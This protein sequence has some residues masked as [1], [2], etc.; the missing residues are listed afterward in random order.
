MQW[1]II[2][3]NN[4]SSDATPQ[5]FEGLKQQWS[6]PIPL[7]YLF[8]PQ[9]GIAF[10]RQCGVEQAQGRLV[11][12]L[13]DDNWPTERWIA[14]AV[15]FHDQYPQAGAYG[16]R[17]EG[18]FE[19]PPPPEVQPLFRF[20]A[21]R[22]HGPQ[23][24]RFQPERLQLPAGAGLVVQRQPWL[25]HIPKRITRTTRGGNDYEISVRLARAGWEIWYNPDMVIQHLITADRLEKAYLKKLAFRYGQCTADLSTLCLTPWQ[26]RLRVLKGAL[27]ASKR[28][29][30]GLAKRYLQQD[31]SLIQDCNIAFH[32]GDLKGEITHLLNHIKSIN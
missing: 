6:S 1:E 10:A 16:G 22:N 17:C 15:A 32:W 29:L 8:E 25:D 13:D 21:I 27:G 4:N 30:Y 19:V 2:V 31:K 12:F 26:T 14:E 28:L 7:R 11:G 3:V 20:L 23:P 9:Q 24:M 5:V 18:V